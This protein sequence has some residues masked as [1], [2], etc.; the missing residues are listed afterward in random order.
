MS[1]NPAAVFLTFYLITVKYSCTSVQINEMAP[2]KKKEDSSHTV[3][4]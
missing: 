1:Q 3:G 2:P 4:S